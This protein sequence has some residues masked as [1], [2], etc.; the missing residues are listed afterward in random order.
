[1][2]LRG[3]AACQRRGGLTARSPCPGARGTARPLGRP[4]A[5]GEPALPRARSTAGAPQRWGL[6]RALRAGDEAKA[7]LWP[8]ESAGLAQDN[9]PGHF[10]L[11]ARVGTHGDTKPI[12]V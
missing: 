6:R 3:P 11:V 10:P 8:G 9:G 7:L 5:W 4:G 12:S 1:M 2:F